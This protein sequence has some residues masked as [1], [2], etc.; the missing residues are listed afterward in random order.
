M[1]KQDIPNWIGLVLGILATCLLLGWA[2]RTHMPKADYGVPGSE[3][4]SVMTNTSPQMLILGDSVIGKER[5]VD[6]VAHYLM[7]ATGLTTMNGAFGGTSARNNNIHNEYTHHE[8]SLTLVELKDAI[9]TGD[10]GI[11]LADYPSNQF[12]SEYFPYTLSQM[13]RTDYENLSVI[14]LGYGVNDYLSGEPCDN[15]ENPYDEGTY[16]GAMRLSIEAFQK[17]FP[18]AQIVLI[19]PNYC[20]IGTGEDGNHVDYGYGTLEDFADG[21]IAVGKEYDLP[22]IDIY[23][24]GVFGPENKEIYLEDGLHLTWE[25]RKAYGE[26][27]AGELTRILR[28]KGVLAPL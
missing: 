4:E 10:F 19:T 28:E 25:G 23:H 18:K 24:S 11:Q 8:S 27:A 13:A 22:V 16:L 15:P 5:N 7:N 6:S 3:G 1:K 26:Y 9:I 2:A 12:G 14:L 21:L 20:W 17:R